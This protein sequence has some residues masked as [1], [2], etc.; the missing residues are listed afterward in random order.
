M[1]LLVFIRG[2]GWGRS[3]LS[4]DAQISLTPEASSSSSG[5]IPRCYQAS[6]GTQRVVGL[7]RGLL[8]VRHACNASL[9]RCSIHLSWLLS[10]QRCSGSPPSSSWVGESG[11]VDWPINR[12]L[13]LSTVQYTNCITAEATPIHL[14]T[15]HC[16]TLQ[17]PSEGKALF[18]GWEQWPRTWRCWLSS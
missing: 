11:C 15:S 1:N 17:Q 16:W 7:P 14:S 6:Q 3:S 9:E 13:C 4:R 18:S 12:E 8:Q 5:R 10:V 2:P